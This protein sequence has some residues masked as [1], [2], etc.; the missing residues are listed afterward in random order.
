MTYKILPKIGRRRGIMNNG[1]QNDTIRIMKLVALESSKNPWIKSMVKKY[2]LNES[3]ESLK[4]LFNFAFYNTFFEPDEP[5][6]QTVKSP[7]SSL[8]ERR[9]NCVDYSVLLSAFLINMGVPHSFR[10]VSTDKKYP[11]SYGHIYVVLDNGLVMDCVIGQDQNG[12]EIYKE[13]NQRIPFPF[14]EV[15]FI[16]NSDLRI[17]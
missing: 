2:N 9:A 17:L 15:E 14:E 8:T 4:N 5:K 11:N 1:K 7:I 3:K 10:M 12:A 13:K 6:V 16:N